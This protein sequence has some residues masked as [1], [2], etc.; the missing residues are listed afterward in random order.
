[1]LKQ[2]QLFY[3]NTYITY[4]N[5]NF[6]I[7]QVNNLLEGLSTIDLKEIQQIKEDIDYIFDG[8][9]VE[10]SLTEGRINAL[11][12]ECMSDFQSFQW[13]CCLSTAR[14]LVRTD[15][16][17][18]SIYL[19]MMGR[20][21][22]SLNAI[23]LSVFVYQKTPI[24]KLYLWIGSLWRDPHMMSIE[25]INNEPDSVCLEWWKD[26][27]KLTVY[28]DSDKISYLQVSG[29]SILNDMVDGILTEENAEGVFQ[30]ILK[31]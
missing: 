13:K 11:Y 10:N 26:K 28:I 31:G 19:F 24:Y 27:K 22:Q 20:C 9:P 4:K 5:N 23:D 1:M 8:M 7:L 2:N 12:A 18:R 25:S 16:K 6:D 29:P 14:M 30:W 17:Y 21:Y 15:S 3:I